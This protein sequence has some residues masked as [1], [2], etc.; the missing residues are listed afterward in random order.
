MGPDPYL[1]R[2]SAETPGSQGRLFFGIRV[3]SAPFG[4]AS[5]GLWALPAGLR[6][7]FGL[8]W[9]FSN[10]SCWGETAFLCSLGAS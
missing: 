5:F 7:K 1:P 4:L 2:N 9:D 10:N 3:G 8:R 6:P